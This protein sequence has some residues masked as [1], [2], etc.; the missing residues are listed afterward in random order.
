VTL[1]L[2]GKS[3]PDLSTLSKDIDFHE[4]EGKPVLLCLT[5]IAQ[6]PSRRCLKE[7][8]DQAEAVAGLPDLS[9]PTSQKQVAMR[10]FSL[11]ATLQYLFSSLAC[12]MDEGL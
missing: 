6:R 3:L 2:L 8:A 11:G 10:E 12:L 9:L 5:D 4:I 1:S 7:L